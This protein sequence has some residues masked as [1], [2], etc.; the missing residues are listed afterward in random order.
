MHS[1]LYTAVKI[2]WGNGVEGLCI[3]ITKLILLYG[4]ILWWNS[5]LRSQSAYK[6]RPLIESAKHCR[7]L[8]LQRLTLCSVSGKDAAIRYAIRL[9]IS[10]FFFNSAYEHSEILKDFNGKHICNPPRGECEN[11]SLWSRVLIIFSR[12]DRSQLPEL[13]EVCSVSNS[14]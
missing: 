6:C 12:T 3:I 9:S 7:P 2:T 13:R 5:L 1:W 10:S 14:Q 4:V 8:A 11:A